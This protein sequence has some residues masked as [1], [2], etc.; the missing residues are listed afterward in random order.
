MS[1][2]KI[3]S[4]SKKHVEFNRAS[5]FLLLCIISWLL[6]SLEHQNPTTR[7]ERA[8]TTMTKDSVKME[9][10]LLFNS[11]NQP[12]KY[13][14]YVV[15]P[16]CEEGVCYN[17]IA[18]VY[19]DLLGNFMDYK[20]TVLDPLTKF[21]HIK[22]TRE[23][24]D[25]MKEIL[26]D[27]TSLLANYKAEDLVDHSIEIKSEVIDGVAGATYK[28]LSGAVVRGAVYSSHTLWHIVNGEVAD[29]IV[30]HTESL[31]NDD[32][33]IWMLDSD[34]Y[35]LQFY[36][37]NKIDTGNEQY[38]PNLI[39]LISEGNSYVPFFA[40]EKIPEWAWSSALYQPKIVI[41][42]KEVEFR[43]QNEILNK[44]NNRELEENSITV[45]TSSMESLNKSQLKKAFNILNNNRDR[46]SVES[47]GEIESLS[48]SGNK[49]ISEAAE[50]FLTSLEK[51]GG[52]VS[53]KMKEQRKKLISN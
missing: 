44:L 53:K 33:L 21:D 27:K 50:Q 42:L 7:K 40:I 45:L 48:E 10:D 23:D 30:A 31:M 41:L 19:W 15:T 1:K 2:T 49:E 38:T 9:V 14:S 36:A 39:R 37:L 43:M 34:N 13:Y 3:S 35:N 24:H 32:L 11:K 29:K 4:G 18:E 5:R 8:F 52:L 47:I 28:S 20:E 51:E 12:V 22:F 26:R 25:K 17:L 46:L 16:V 6:M